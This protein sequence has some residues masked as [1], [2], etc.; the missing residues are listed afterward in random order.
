MEQTNPQSGGETNR[1]WRDQYEVLRTKH[2]HALNKDF[3]FIQRKSKVSNLNSGLYYIEVD[4][5][6]LDPHDELTRFIRSNYEEGLKPI[7][8]YSEGSNAKLDKWDAVGTP[9]ALAVSYVFSPDSS[10]TKVVLK[11]LSVY[12]EWAICQE[13]ILSGNP[14]VHHIEMIIHPC[15]ISKVFVLYSTSNGLDGGRH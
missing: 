9:L 5:N 8:E 7:V 12:S 1:L 4:F 14:T 6:E 2:V 3:I 10:T 15:D 13:D 11:V